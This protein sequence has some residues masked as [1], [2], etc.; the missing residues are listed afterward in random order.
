M[1]EKFRGAVERRAGSRTGHIKQTAFGGTDRLIEGTVQRGLFSNRVSDILESGYKVRGFSLFYC[2]SLLL[3][4]FIFF[5]SG[6]VNNGVDRH[7]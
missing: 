6:A 2:F 5:Y 3:Q 7:D 1:F 4:I